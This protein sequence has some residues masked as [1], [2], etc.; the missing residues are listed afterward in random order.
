MLLTVPKRRA[1]ATHSHTGKHQVPQESEEQEENKGT[2]TFLVVAERR[3]DEAGQA[4]EQ[5]GS[6]PQRWSLVVKCLVLW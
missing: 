1:H 6:Q 3:K 2:K 4:A 5:A